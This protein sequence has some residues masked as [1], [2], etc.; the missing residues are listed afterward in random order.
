MSGIKRLA[1]NDEAKVSA[2]IE[3]IVECKN[4]SNPFVFITRAKNASDAH[5]RP[6]HFRYPLTYRMTKSLDRSR[7]IIRE[8]DGFF[9][10]GFNKTHY[11]HRLSAKAV[12]FCRIDRKGNSWHANHG[13]LYDA[14][15]YPMAKAVNA[16]VAEIPKG[17]RPN[18]WKYI[19]L[20][21]P[22]IVTSGDLLVVDSAKSNSFPEPE[23]WV[24]FSRELKSG[25]LNGTYTIDFV[26]QA[27]LEKFIYECID[28]LAELARELVE[29]K[30]DSLLRAEC[31]WQD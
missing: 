10:L 13:G 15:F 26:R 6:E 18:E 22:I 1:R 16:R 2:F 14:I 25:K 19:W 28:P 31:P 17:S 24:G 11:S 30:S 12:Q 7:V 20:L 29:S 5:A 27:Q 8:T 9:H 4:S 21:F 23:E 3:L